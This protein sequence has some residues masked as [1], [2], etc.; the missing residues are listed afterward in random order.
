MG[1]SGGREGVE[2]DGLGEYWGHGVFVCDEDGLFPG[3]VWR[4]E[5]KREGTLNKRQIDGDMYVTCFMLS[6]WGFIL[7]SWMYLGSMH[8]VS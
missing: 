6:L 5:G 2:R 1:E 7:E 4:R 8:Y 3:M